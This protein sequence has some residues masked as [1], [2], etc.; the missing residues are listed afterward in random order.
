LI[1]G[2]GKIL[3][4]CLK[5]GSGR[6]KTSEDAKPTGRDPRKKGNLTAR[7]QGDHRQGAKKEKK[8]KGSVAGKRKDNGYEGRI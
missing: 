3:Q 5:H 4:A 6:G 2:G 1:L 7:Y 8:E